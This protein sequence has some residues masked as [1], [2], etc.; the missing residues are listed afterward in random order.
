MIGH[1]SEY[2]V[3]LIRERDAARAEN[4]QLREALFWISEYPNR[5]LDPEDAGIELAEYARAAV[6]EK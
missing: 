1:S 3:Q 4:Q 2:V 6:G 5:D